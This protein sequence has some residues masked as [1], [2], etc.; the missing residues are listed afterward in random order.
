VSKLIGELLVEAKALTREQ[1]EDALR[2]PREP[3]KKLGHILLERGFVNEAQLTQ[4]LSLQLAVPWVSLYHIDFS[5]QLLSRVPREIAEEHCLVPIYVRHVKGSGET[6]YVAIEDPTNDEALAAASRA[7]SL[8]VRPMIASPS[9]IRSAIRVYYGGTASG[10]AE[11]STPSL[12]ELVPPQESKPR[13]PPPL[14]PKRQP[15]AKSTLPQANDTGAH[16]LASAPGPVAPIPQPPPSRPPP[17]RNA[18]ARPARGGPSKLPGPDSPDAAPEIE[19]REIT[20]P[21][22]RGPRMVALTLLDGTSLT[23]PARPRRKSEHPPAGISDQLTSRDLISALRALSHGADVS[24]ILGD[25]VHWEAMFAALLSILLKRGII[26]DWEFVDE[27][28]KV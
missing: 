8:P 25:N 3:G 13:E 24:E 7:A 18:S 11:P 1:L 27:L 28:R 19:A 4:S 17:P 9:D 16:A 23:L 26:A 2:Q 20:M 14:P 6:L 15:N 22:K 21:G 10:E 5:R 12:P